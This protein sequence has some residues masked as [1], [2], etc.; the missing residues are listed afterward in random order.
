MGTILTALLTSLITTFVINV[1]YKQY[2]NYRMFKID[3]IESHYVYNNAF[4]YENMP[5]SQINYISEGRIKFRKLA[6]QAEGFSYLY[7]FQLIGLQS[8]L[9]LISQDLIKMSNHVGHEQLEYNKAFDSI[10]ERALLFML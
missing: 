6:G 8:N 7:S 1:I 9:L 5:T 2:E 10:K 3:I 4:S